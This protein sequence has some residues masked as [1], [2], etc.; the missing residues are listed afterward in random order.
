MFRHFW[1]SVIAVFCVVYCDHPVAQRLV[2]HSLSKVII[3]WSLSYTF[4]QLQHTTH[5]FPH[6]FIDNPLQCAA[7]VPQLVLRWRVWPATKWK[8]TMATKNFMCI[9]LAIINMTSTMD[10]FQVLTASSR[11][12]LY[13]ATWPRWSSTMV[14]STHQTEFGKHLCQHLNHL[15]LRVTFLHWWRWCQ[16]LW[17]CSRLR[18]N[19]QLRVVLMRVPN[20]VTLLHPRCFQNPR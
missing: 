20:S 10:I 12:E 6:T 9:K 4:L 5:Q 1:V 16:P 18:P 14:L 13:S 15:L 8:P 19:Y 11:M 7:I 3:I 2:A 17:I